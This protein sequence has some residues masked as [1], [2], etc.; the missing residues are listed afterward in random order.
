MLTVTPQSDGTVSVVRTASVSGGLSAGGWGGN[1]GPLR[2]EGGP[3]GT[4]QAR[5]PG[6]ARLGLPGPGDRRALPRARDPQ[7]ARLQALAVDLAVRRARDRRGRSGQ[8]QGG[9]GR[10]GGRLIGGSGSAQMAVGVK[11]SS[12]GSLTT[13]SRMTLERGEVSVPFSTPVL[14]A[15][16]SDWIVELT[17]EKGGGSARARAAHATIAL[18]RQARHRDDRPAGSA[19]PGEPGGR[20]AVPGRADPVDGARRRR[21]SSAVLDRI[22]T[23]GDRRALGSRPSRTARAG[24]RRRSKLGIKLSLGGKKIKI[25]RR[26]DR[27]DGDRRRR[28]GR[29]SGST[30]CPGRRRHDRARRRP[31]TRLARPDA[32]RDLS[33]RAARPRSRRGVQHGG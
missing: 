22:A 12:D 1:L 30:A 19:R 26:L 33:P 29:D 15:G 3:E 18:G 7:R 9:I 28:A 27:G 25:L 4:V 11:Q 20:A 6:R 14:A 5:V 10:G 31:R 24:C 17:R 8:G 21:P 32:S 16:R 13:Y 2:L 23:H